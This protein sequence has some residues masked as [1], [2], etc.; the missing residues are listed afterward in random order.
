M[1]LDAYVEEVRK[2]HVADPNS[3]WR[4]LGRFRSLLGDGRLMELE[5]PSDF[6]LARMVQLVIIKEKTAYILTAGALKE[7]FSKFY[8]TFD[9]VLRSLQETTNLVQ[10]YPHKSKELTALI[11]NLYQKCAT[12]KEVWPPFEKKIINDFTEMGPYWQILLL[13]EV[14]TKIS[15]LRSTHE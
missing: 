9:S 13:N 10:S 15:T 5:T 2:I 7:E 14:Q 3:R 11:D 12:E 4:D 8:R 6:G 1:S